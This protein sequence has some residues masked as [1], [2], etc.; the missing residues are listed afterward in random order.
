MFKSRRL[1]LAATATVLAII[2][3]Y[4]VWN[5]INPHWGG[6]ATDNF[7]AE[8]ARQS[9][10]NRDPHTTWPHLTR[11]NAP[12]WYATF[13][14]P[15]QTFGN[16]QLELPMR[17]TPQR[18]T[19]VLLPLGDFDAQET[20][21][22]EQLRQFCATFFALPARLEKPLSL[23][24]L[25]VPTRA[26]RVNGANQTQLDADAILARLSPRLP[27]DAAAYL[28]I[29]NRDLWSDR[30]NF[31]FGL[32]SYRQRV[33]VYSLARYRTKGA[34]AKAQLRRACQVL[35]HETGHMFG[36]SH[37]VFYRCAMN[38]SNSLADADGAPLDFCPACERKLQWNIGYNADARDAA[39]GEFYATHFPARWIAALK[40]K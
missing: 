8:R 18:R 15:V 5:A 11:E 39:L 40:L 24:N 16:Y 12:G 9:E 34:P 4:L 22:L 36:I 10:W 38:G 14:E 32:A 1:K 28:A 2:A 19:L 21:E 31:V 6:A 13:A 29:T 17:P 33:G 26:G 35:C 30:L 7:L 37:C 25:N 3:G 20:R 23:D 27:D